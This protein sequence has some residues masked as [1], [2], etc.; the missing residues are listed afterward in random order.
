MA[1]DAWRYHRVGRRSQQSTAL[2]RS[3]GPCTFQPRLLDGHADAILFNPLKI[4]PGFDS[5]RIF[6]TMERWDDGTWILYLNERVRRRNV[7][8]SISCQ[9]R[10]SLAS[11]YK[12]TKEQFHRNN[13]VTLYIFQVSFI[14]AD[15]DISRAV[16]GWMGSYI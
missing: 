12:F 16:L 5:L 2:A 8:V 4:T 6:W 10:V 11:I 15:V 3:K 14:E 13:E 9:F 1:Y 7:F